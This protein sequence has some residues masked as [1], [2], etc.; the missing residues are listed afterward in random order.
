MNISKWGAA[1]ALALVVSGTAAACGSSE[2]PSTFTAVD[3]RG[4][5][6]GAAANNAQIGIL[7]GAV[8]AD[9]ALAFLYP[10]DKTVF[11]RGILAPLLQWDP[12]GH[13]FDALYIHISEKAFDYKGYFQKP[14]GA[15]TFINH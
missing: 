14:A 9:P 4:G 13:A 5:C 6:P 8:T 3:A 12:D 2:A 1:L 11:P 10:Y 7:N 15:A